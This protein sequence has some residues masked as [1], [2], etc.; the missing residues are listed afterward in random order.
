MACR[1]SVD[2]YICHCKAVTD[3]RIRSAIVDGARTIDEVSAQCRAGT[4]CG[5]CWPALFDM[6][7]RLAV[8]AQPVDILERCLPHD[9]QPVEIAATAAAAAVA[10]A[11]A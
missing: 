7:E 5:G 10:V 3:D 2:V 4:G 1:R 11:V 8:S 6:L 9:G